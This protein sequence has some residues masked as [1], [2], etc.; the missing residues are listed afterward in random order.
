MRRSDTLRRRLDVGRLQRSGKLG[1][2]I[3]QYLLFVEGIMY[4]WRHVARQRHDCK[5]N[6]TTVHSWTAFK[7]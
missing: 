1:V 7:F 2:S 6:E 5:T 4:N 3:E